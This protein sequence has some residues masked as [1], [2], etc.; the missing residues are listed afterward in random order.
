MPCFQPLKTAFA[1]KIRGMKV[2]LAKDGIKKRKY[3]KSFY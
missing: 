2:N 1:L 3:M